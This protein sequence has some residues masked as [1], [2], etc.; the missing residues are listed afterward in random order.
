MKEGS[1]MRKINLNGYLWDVN[2]YIL[3]FFDQFHDMHTFNAKQLLTIIE[4]TG[5]SEKITLE[6]CYHYL[7][8]VYGQITKGLW[9]AT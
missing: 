4:K 6:E 3:F 8:N 7:T 9:D 1:V 2:N 5:N